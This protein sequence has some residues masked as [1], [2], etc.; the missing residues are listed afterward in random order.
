MPAVV[1]GGKFS[2]RK[3]LA[4]LGAFAVSASDDAQCVSRSPVLLQLEL[5]LCAG[6]LRRWDW[7]SLS[8]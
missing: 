4:Q 6:G 2:C 3:G 7:T 1:C 5:L 8:H